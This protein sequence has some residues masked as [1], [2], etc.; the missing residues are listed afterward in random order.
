MTAF[1]SKFMQV[2]VV[3]S[4][5]EGLATGACLSGSGNAY[6]SISCRSALI[7]HAVHPV[8]EN[9]LSIDD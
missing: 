3:D 7:N 4:G 6:Q 1:R 8:S 2:K 9:M 5:Y